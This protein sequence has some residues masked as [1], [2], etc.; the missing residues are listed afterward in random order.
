LR[1]M[2]SFGDIMGRMQK[3][4]SSMLIHS[5]E[6][7]ALIE[8]SLIE[9]INKKNLAYLLLTSKSEH[10]IR[11][12]VA[13]R[14]YDKYG[15]R[16]LLIAREYGEGREKTDLA[17]LDQRKPNKEILLIEFKLSA[18]SRNI[19]IAGDYGRLAKKKA[20][21]HIVFLTLLPE[22]QIKPPYSG[23]VRKSYINQIN[24]KA[25]KVK[26]GFS[27]VYRHWNSVVDGITKKGNHVEKSCLLFNAGRFYGYKAT[28]F[29][30]VISFGKK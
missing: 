26:K 25:D 1:Y 7:V 6:V 23:L 18:T 11:D 28:A 20:R 13:L 29:L 14:L 16:G 30:G 10:Y 22:K 24:K 2:N 8:E 12:K 3:E 15:K 19:D 9:N 17:V 21:C 5:K 4:G 27:D